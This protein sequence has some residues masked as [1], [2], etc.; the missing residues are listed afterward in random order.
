VSERERG[1]WC[2]VAGVLALAQG[3]WWYRATQT[4]PVSMISQDKRDSKNKT[5]SITTLQS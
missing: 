5:I 2:R 4:H 3:G 1:G